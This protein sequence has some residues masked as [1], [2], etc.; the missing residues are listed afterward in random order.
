MEND[1]TFCFLNDHILSSAELT[2]G[3]LAATAP[4]LMFF[5]RQQRSNL[6]KVAD[7]VGNTDNRKSGSDEAVV[8]I[9]AM[10]VR[11]RMCGHGK[12]NEGSLLRTGDDSQCSQI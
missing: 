1:I 3:I 12:Y 10:P 5:I 2:G 8:T 4:S 11:P 9:G 6:A 7:D